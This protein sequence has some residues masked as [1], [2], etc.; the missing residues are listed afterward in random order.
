MHGAVSCGAE[1]SH[2]GVAAP[3][4][5]GPQVIEVFREHGQAYLLEHG[6]S[7]AQRRVL[8]DLCA[9]RTAAMGGNRRTCSEC[10]Y[11]E[12]HYNSCG[13]RHC[14]NCR[15]LSRATWLSARL[16]R[17]L[18]V[19]HFFVTFTVPEPLRVIALQNE[20]AVYDL[21]L[22]AV[23]RTIGTLGRSVLGGTMGVMA[24][25]HTWTRELLYHPHVHAV[26]TGGA[27]L[28]GGGGWV[29]TGPSFLFPHRRLAAIFRK[30]MVQGLFR[31]YDEERLEFQGKASGLSESWAFKRLMRKM[32]KTTWVVDVEA[33][34][35]GAR[36]EQALKYLARYAQGVAISDQRMV[37]SRGESVTFKT[38]DAKRL[39]LPWQEFVRR[40]LLHVLPRGFNKL[41]YYGLY[42]SRAE[43]EHAKARALLAPAEQSAVVVKERPLCELEGWEERVLALTGVDPLVCPRCGCRDL[44]ITPIERSLPTLWEWTSNT[45]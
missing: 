40:Y 27:L 32:W 1:A 2:G 23:R 44:V 21:M 33:P 43:A 24:A 37:S 12:L 5:R 45:S 35:P 39:S 16:E 38:R 25:L 28:K 6:V 20:R 34:P 36:P 22:C 10:G 8:L 14:P 17:F 30:E 7:L 18:P 41:R 13:N 3:R 26:V 11:T 15:S 42:A 4:A 19:A 29:A 31:L 9:C